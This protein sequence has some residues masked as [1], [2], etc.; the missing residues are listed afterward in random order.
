WVGLRVVIWASARVGKTTGSFPTVVQMTFA[1]FVFVK[2]ATYQ[3]RFFRNPQRKRGI[4][5][6]DSSL[7]YAAGYDED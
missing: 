4:I 3:L 1:F 7:A 5:E 2:R 6:I